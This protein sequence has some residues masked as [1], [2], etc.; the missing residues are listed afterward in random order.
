M[1]DLVHQGYLVLRYD[2]KGRVISSVMWRAGDDN[3]V[4]KQR[5]V[6]VVVG[7]GGKYVRLS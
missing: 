7:S 3:V 5:H 6:F 4:H 1:P 2:T